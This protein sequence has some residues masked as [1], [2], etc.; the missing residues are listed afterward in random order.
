MS[1][2]L[3]S[4]L[5]QIKE[6]LREFCNVQASNKY[7]EGD[8]TSIEDLLSLAHEKLESLYKLWEHV[9]EELDL[10][11]DK[12]VVILGHPVP[13]ASPMQILICLLVNHSLI[14]EKLTTESDEV[15]GKYLNLS[16]APSIVKLKHNIANG[17]LKMYFVCY[18]IRG[19]QQ[20]L[21]IG[22][23]QVDWRG[24]SAIAEIRRA[25]WDCRIATY[26]PLASRVFCAL[27]QAKQEVVLP[28]SM[29]GLESIAKLYQTC[30]WAVTTMKSTLHPDFLGRTTETSQVFNKEMKPTQ[31]CYFCQGMMGYSV[32]VK[33]TKEDARNNICYMIWRLRGSYAH[34]SAEVEVSLQYSQ[35]WT[36]NRKAGNN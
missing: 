27:Q 3:K 7:I 29:A 12:Y 18:H 24:L 21:F 26:I 14:L 32:P 4:T 25:D 35:N 31:C 19:G 1:I 8:L 17:I 20:E 23:N 33:F 2:L 5:D 16:S 22:S 34:S 15:L 28:K 6:G 36:G 11:I 13:T 30:I 9:V 10:E